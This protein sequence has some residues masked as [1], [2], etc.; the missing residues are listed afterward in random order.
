MRNIDIA[1]P[2]GAVVAGAA[3][4]EYESK[5]RTV[6]KF[7]MVAT[8]HH[9]WDCTGIRT[10]RHRRAHSSN[11]VTDESVPYFQC[12]LSCGR[13]GALFPL[14]L[15]TQPKGQQSVTANLFITPGCFAS[16]AVL[17]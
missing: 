10:R 6:R 7:R 5:N 17:V 4:V 15:I 13:C 8:H 12:N 1:S 3:P 2:W 16:A 9:N 14:R 11:L